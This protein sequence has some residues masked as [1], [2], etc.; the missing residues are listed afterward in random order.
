VNAR[1]LL[2]AL[3]ALPLASCA[4]AKVQESPAARVR[5]ADLEPEARK[6][7]EAA[8]AL[9]DAGRK[10]G[11]PDLDGV[12]RRLKAALS[13][14]DRLAEAHHDLGVIAE[15]RGK[16]ED[17]EAH[18][19]EAVEIKSLPD[20]REALA[21]MLERRG[22]SAGAEAQYEAIMAEH[23]EHAG[24]RARLAAL[25]RAGGDTE[26]ATQLAREALMRDPRNL[27]AYDVLI[28]L[29]LDHKET[30]AAK[31]LALQALKIDESDPALHYRVGQVLEQAGDGASALAQ[32]RLA[33]AS[34]QG[35]VPSAFRLGEEAL[36]ARDFARARE[37]F[38]AIV[39]VDPGN[40]AAQM[41]LGVALRA[42]GDL[43]GAL[44]AFDRALSAK[45]GW[46]EPLFAKALIFHRYKDDPDRALAL[47]RAFVSAAA[48]H[49]S[50]QH[51]VFAYMRECEQLVQAKHAS[52]AAPAASGTQG[53][54]QASDPDVIQ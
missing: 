3:A 40:A 14:D 17:A 39:K 54:A 35:H 9:W 38:A 16:A 51:K 34:K 6:E 7:F 42:S 36:K 43:D 22:D 11:K 48:D 4:T 1:P 29:A 45:A 26:R 32:Y 5:A 8:V 52:E 20:A 30:G 24:A 28:G 27:T 44:A 46:A 50:P 13:A 53:P 23:P 25:A 49:L 41:N 37:Q 21:A 18:Y 15:I 12:E 10:S 47:Y 19:R 2:L 33:A 31:L